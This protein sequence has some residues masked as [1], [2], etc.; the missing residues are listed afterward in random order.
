M[1]GFKNDYTWLAKNVCPKITPK[2]ARK[3]VELLEKLGLIKKQKEGG[4]VISDRSK[5]TE[6]E[7]ASLAV[8]NYHLE[9]AKLA[10]EA[11]RHFPKEK[12][13]ITG[14]TLGIS[15]K[16]Y[17]EICEDIAEFRKK[18]AEKDKEANTVYQLN[19]QFFPVTNTKI[20]RNSK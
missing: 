12:R 10:L 9:S 4:F 7:V 11:I 13:N 14:M 20:G 17:D 8:L 1:Y 5:T 3:S 16:V 15:E 18:I 19:F 6:K 2:K